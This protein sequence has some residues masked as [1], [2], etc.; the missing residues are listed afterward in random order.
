MGAGAMDCREWEEHLEE[1]LPGTLSA[2]RRAEADAHLAGCARCSELLAVIQGN[3]ALLSDSEQSDLTAAILERTSGRPCP[4]AR[5]LLPDW[6]GGTLGSL[7]ASL[8][9]QHLERCADCRTLA[10][11]L[12]WLV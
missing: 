10:R 5:E 8:I 7:D 9:G 4:R 3:Q 11:T 1:L 2:A 6:T 12:T